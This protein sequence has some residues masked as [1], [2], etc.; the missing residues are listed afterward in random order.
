M[1]WTDDRGGNVEDRRGLGG[2]A[3][4]G[5]GLGTL[6][7][8]AIIFFLGGDPSSIL[9]SG[10][11]SGSPRTEQRELTAEDKKIGEMVDM[12]G[13]WNITTWDQVFQENGMQYTP[14]K[15]ILFSETTQSGC[16]VAQSAMGPFYCP[17][18]QSVY[19]DMSFF[20]ELQQRFGAKV[21]EF[22][23]AYVLAHEVGH[24]VQTLLGTTQKV[25]QLRRSGKYSEAEMNRVSVATEL[26]ADF[27]AGVWARRTDAEKHILEPGDIQSAIEAAEAVG[28]DNI[29]RRSQ[30][31]VNQE[32]F[33]HGSSAQRKEWFMKGY[34]TGDIRQGDTFNQLLK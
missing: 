31:Y 11:G 30:G 32:S 33:T 22:T 13:K 16:G 27:Y 21:T 26:Q 2:G 23:V 6:I 25:D 19:M 4:V 17:A 14:P 15:I 28:D 29:Q 8:A 24:H 18:D 12:M 9:S 7:I 34:N 3:V 10:A 5:G 1:R 20:N